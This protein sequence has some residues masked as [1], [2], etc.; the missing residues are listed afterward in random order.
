MNAGCCSPQ[1]SP[2]RRCGHGCAHRLAHAARPA[3]PARN[4][5]LVC[6]RR[7]ECSC[8]S[9]LSQCRTHPNPHPDCAASLVDNWSRV[10]ELLYRKSPRR[11]DDKGTR[12]GR[13]TCCSD[14]YVKCNVVCSSDCSQK[15]V[16][17]L[18]SRGAPRNHC[19][20]H[21]ECGARAAHFRWDCL[22][23]ERLPIT[24]HARSSR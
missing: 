17:V 6:E 11:C 18:R 2:M 12:S 8:G 21:M 10:Y 16:R 13:Q 24:Q 15:L 9:H 23:A 14:I 20:N 7:A 22:P 5:A 19:G 4:G 1:I 3:S